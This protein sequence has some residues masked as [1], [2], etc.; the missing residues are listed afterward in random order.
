MSHY[1][2]GILGAG[3]I[4]REMIEALNRAGIGVAV[5]ANRTA[6]KARDLAESYG[7][8]VVYDDYEGIFTDPGVD[9]IYIAT[10]HDNHYAQMKKA[11]AGGK[12][13]L[14]EKAI[15][16]DAAQLEEIMALAAEKNLVVSEAMTI[17]HMPIY[18][19]MQAAA[20][21]EKLGKV[22]MIQVNFGS[23]KAYDVADR[24]FNPALAGGA[25]L[26]IGVYALSFAR[27]FLDSA[28]TRVRTLVQYFET[29]VDEQSG[30]V[31]QNDD[32]QM[33]VIALTMRAK[34]PKRGVV[35]AER[36]YIE[37]ENYPRAD[38]ATL[39]LTETGEVKA[40]TAGA[41]ADALIY[42]ARD[43]EAAVAAGD[44]AELRQMTLDVMRL[45]S[46]IRAQWGKDAG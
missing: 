12:H 1:R 39:T 5:I 9:I 14:C 34:Q 32:G 26:D 40:F 3:R 10:T 17:Y 35:A 33:V 27:Y 23:C 38:K 8:P 7:I 36:G 42:E 16:V 18:R 20:A 28:P 46:A 13:V 22:K 31:L 44:G 11:L 2:W 41:S 29:G 45:I 15:T 21:R 25:L 30:I 6:A 19:C 43:M 37:I 24:F 4:A